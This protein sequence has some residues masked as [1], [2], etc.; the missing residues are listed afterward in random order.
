MEIAGLMPQSCVAATLDDVA[1]S[2]LSEEQLGQ[3]V[4]SLLPHRPVGRRGVDAFAADCERLCAE[5]ALAEEA[6][7]DA[8]S[9]ARSGFLLAA[10]WRPKHGLLGTA[11]LWA[12]GFATVCGALVLLSGLI[13]ARAPVGAD[14]AV[15]ARQL[16][17]LTLERDSIRGQL[18]AALVRQDLLRREVD[19]LHASDASGAIGA[20]CASDAKGAGAAGGA[21]G[22]GGARRAGAALQCRP[23]PA[24][25]PCPAP[26]PCPMP[27]AAPLTAARRVDEEIVFRGG[28]EFACRD[29]GHLNLRARLHAFEQDNDRL[30][31]EPRRLQAAYHAQSEEIWSLRARVDECCTSLSSIGEPPE[32]LA[33]CAQREAAINS[34]TE[35]GAVAPVREVGEVG[36]AADLAAAKDAEL[37]L[38]RRRLQ[39]AKEMSDRGRT[40]MSE[41]PS[42]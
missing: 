1:L 13:S 26:L 22:A 39:D 23:C 17:A 40:L 41:W 18:S 6:Q 38:C 19:L 25:V 28:D 35:Q 3:L 15:L 42:R 36:D 34:S 30:R 14:E 20:S 27:L 9:K 12:I 5:T 10:P 31:E 24:T 32:M 37:L 7:D 4:A 11:A 33:F 16:E 2:Q 29:E 21:G 8:P